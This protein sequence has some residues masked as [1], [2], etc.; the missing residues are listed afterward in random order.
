MDSDSINA[1]TPP[2]R[3]FNSSFQ[4]AG[5]GDVDDAEGVYFNKIGDKMDTSRQF[6]AA[7]VEFQ[8]A[9]ETRKQRGVCDAAFKVHTLSVGISDAGMLVGR[10]LDVAPECKATRRA[11][12][13]L[14]NLTKVR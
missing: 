11:R 6:I 1:N 2:R 9:L 4:A 8:A 13:F 12:V 3:P 10:V 14:S 7:L 5:A